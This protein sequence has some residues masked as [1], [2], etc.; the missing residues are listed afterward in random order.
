MQRIHHT[1]EQVLDLSRTYNQ[2]FYKKPLGLWYGIDNSWR[3]WLEQAENPDRL[4]AN[5]FLLDIDIS[6]ILIIDSM[7]K[8]KAFDSEF[9]YMPENLKNLDSV[10]WRIDWQGLAQRYSGIEIA[11]YQ[12]IDSFRFCAWYSSWNVASGCI[13][14]LSVIKSLKKA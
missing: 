4:G 5:H 10:Y 7:D 14:D 12:E 11:P 1:N 6:K 13:W 2:T 9:S 3:D 8:L